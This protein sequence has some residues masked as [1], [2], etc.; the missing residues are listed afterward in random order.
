MKVITKGDLI[1]KFGERNGQIMWQRHMQQQAGLEISRNVSQNRVKEVGRPK[2]GETYDN[3]KTVL[4][5]PSEPKGDFIGRMQKIEEQFLSGERVLGDAICMSLP[6]N[7][8][9]KEG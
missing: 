5:P 6:H 8:T 4:V 1:A 2:K 3:E 9:E 7:K